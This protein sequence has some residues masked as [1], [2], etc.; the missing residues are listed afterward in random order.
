[1]E[2]GNLFN[3]ISQIFGGDKMDMISRVLSLFLQK[4]E[5]PSQNTA[6]NLPN[7][8]DQVWQLPKFE[9]NPQQK[10][11]FNQQDFEKSKNNFGQSSFAQTPQSHQESPKQ[12]L[13]FDPKTILEIAKIF[14]ELFE[15]LKSTK[16]EEDSPCFVENLKR[17]ED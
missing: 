1:M 11:F 5:Q 10:T 14:K 3:T 4:N 8:N 12:T 17:C 9:I 15:N 16:K 7:P 6:P 13:N 2:F